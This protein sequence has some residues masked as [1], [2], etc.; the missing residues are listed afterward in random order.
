M[1]FFKKIIV[2]I[3]TWE[4]R[5]VLAR[6]KPTIIAVTGSVGKTT[7]KDAIF[8]TLAGHLHVRKSEKSFNSDVGVPLTILGL[9]NGWHD[10][11]K[12]ISNIARGF[13]TLVV[14]SDYPKFLVLEVGADRPGDIKNIAVWLRPDVA[15]IT[16]IPEVPVHVEF[17]D[18]P[19]AVL[20]EKRALAEH[21]KPG[22]KIIVNGDDPRLCDLKSDF[23]GLTT[24]YGME[25]NNDFVGSHDEILYEE[26]VATGQR[27][28][29][30]HAGSSVPV[31]LYGALGRPRIYAALAGIAV[32]EVLGID[33]VSSS[34]GL[35]TWVP[36][37]GR[38][39][40]VAGLRDS[41]I[42]DD[43]YNSSPAAAL[44][45]LDT[46]QIV[47]TAGRKIAIMGDMLELGK[48]STDAHKAVGE[49]AAVC[50][51]MLITVG[52]RARTIA[53]S[54]L[55][56]GMDP[57]QVRS[58]ELGESARAGLELEREI[59]EGDVV[60]VK[61][62]QSIRME[63]TVEVLMREPQKAKDLLVR[64]EEEWKNR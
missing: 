3:L 44:A 48:Y 31:V 56:A 51:D 27:F 42:I 4:A 23:R 64:Q 17:F 35:A 14:R 25:D 63:R 50:A 37:P 19:E 10:P 55:D 28:R 41:T 57:E 61:G 45:G 15:V 8:S 13:L 5:A 36:P 26:R 22:G 46:L 24:T 38:M 20:R 58:Y 16:A 47:S 40:L 33:T 59:K 6:Y 39:R 11:L 29:V 7:T 21:L 2:L 18:S 54:A 32:A 60:L 53:E 30:N 1:Q 9:D 62:S 12:W 49:R 52:F 43:T 34:R